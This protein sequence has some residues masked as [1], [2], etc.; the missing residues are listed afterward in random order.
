VSVSTGGEAPRGLRY[1]AARMERDAEPQAERV[2]A[3]AIAMD[4]DL[5]PDLPTADA[6]GGETSTRWAGTVD[7]VS[8]RVRSTGPVGRAFEAFLAYAALSGLLFVR[9]AFAHL[10]SWCIS[11]CRQDT[12]VYLWSFRWMPFALGD[13]L[14]PL[15]TTHY[16]WAPGGVNLAWV[17]TLPGPSFV[18]TPVTLIWG[19][20][21]S[22][23]L[24]LWLAPAL[25]GWAC[26]LLCNQ[27]TSRFGPAFAGGA[28]F[29]F[30]SYVG[31]HMRGHVNLLLMFC[32]PIAVYLVVRRVRGRIGSRALVLLLALT[33]LGQF[34]ISTEIFVTMTLFGGAA[35]VLAL[36]FASKDVRRDLLGTTLLIGFAYLIVF[37]IVSPYVLE[38]IRNRPPGSVRPLEANSTD[39]LSYVLPR[40]PTWLGAGTF[41]QITS[42]SL[43]RASDDTAYVG[44]VLLLI[45]AL[46][47]WFGR[48]SRWTWMLLTF[49]LVPV[50]FSFGPTMRVGG[51][52]GIA[53]PGAAL[54]SAPVISSAFPERFPLFAWL[55]I[56]VIVSLFL[57]HA[58]GL[59][60]WRWAL[61]LL[62]AVTLAVSLPSPP[63]RTE[64]RVPAFF[65][66]GTYQQYLRQG[67]TDLLLP[68]HVGDEML[69]QEAAG[70]W[71]RQSR[72]Y[73]G[74]AHRLGLSDR[75][76]G[77]ATVGGSYDVRTPPTSRF[78]RYL[79]QQD[80]ATV[81][82]RAPAPRAWD[83]LFARLGAY[84]I[85]TGGV[86]LYRA[87]PGGWP[88]SIR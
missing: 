14:N 8:R 17:T 51:R 16:V 43:E 32:V 13:G 81:I 68:A 54:A 15:F 33:L 28:I 64:L 46:F 10:S 38:V 11:G 60:P 44:P 58:P 71:F 18:L 48:H 36:V 24:I 3:H 49:I 57:A 42:R 25:A 86:T 50:V 2:G 65:A 29:G 67:E 82:L 12:M 26:Y 45:V 52:G 27:F 70:F 22:D 56:A 72:G 78:L 62:G 79:Q 4:A 66:D 37:V 23:N 80:V 34:S 35:L 31:H 21:A 30:S 7:R 19:G 41:R 40:S 6:D 55:G 59:S 47:A 53:M 77:V 84:A 61:V 76:P 1:R 5:G 74:D 88:P 75:G 9:G 39:P 73:V 20:L 85:T 69:W 87:P 63:Y 83:D